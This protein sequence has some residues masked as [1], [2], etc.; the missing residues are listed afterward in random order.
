[1]DQAIESVKPFTH[2]ESVIVPMLNGIAHI[3][4]LQASFSKE[5]VIGGLC[6][7]ESTVTSEGVIKQPS[8]VHHFVYGELDGQITERIKKL[9]ELFSGTKAVFKMSPSIMTEL[10]HKY[11]F[12]TTM[13]GVTTLFQQPVG[14]IQDVQESAEVVKGLIAEITSILRA[15]KAPIDED[16]EELQFKRFNEMGYEM[17]SSMQRDMEK[18]FSVE[19]D[20]IQGYLLQRASEHRIDTPILRTIYANLKLYEKT[21]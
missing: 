8:A 14:P 4:Q 17:K 11:L 20:H 21:L 16:V 1:M 18:G 15:E 3:Y 2:P 19:A 10:W 9:E 12:I 6:F 13:S 7:I 5:Q